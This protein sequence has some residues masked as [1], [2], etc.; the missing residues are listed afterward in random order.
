MGNQIKNHRIW[1]L[2]ILMIKA[3]NSH[4]SHCA[5]DKIRTVLPSEIKATYAYQLICLS[6]VIKTD[7]ERRAKSKSNKKL[8][9]HDYPSP[10]ELPGLLGQLV[11]SFAQIIAFQLVRR[12]QYD[13]YR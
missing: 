5:A 11:T 1:I 12:E 8:E 3:R 9:A 4:Q 10:R 2:T 13:I 6:T 7:P